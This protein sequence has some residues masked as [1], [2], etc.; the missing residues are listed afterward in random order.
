MENFTE[1]ISGEPL[2]Q[3]TKCKRGSQI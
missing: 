3:G 1:I 2:Y